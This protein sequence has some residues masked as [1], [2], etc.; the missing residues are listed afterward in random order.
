[1]KRNVRLFAT[2]SALLASLSF[3]SA[4]Q[5]Q[6][7]FNFQFTSVDNGASTGSGYLDLP[8]DPGNGTFYYGDLSPTY[9]FTFGGNS[10]NQSHYISNPYQTQ[11]VISDLGNGQRGLVFSD[12]GGPK[13]GGG[14]QYG[15]IDLDYADN[16]LTFSPANF[17]PG[18]L[19]ESGS[20][21][22]AFTA[23][24][25]GAPAATATPEPG[26]VA[27]FVGMGITGAALLRRRRRPLSSSR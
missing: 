14:Q 1:M 8:S 3:A 7:H 23:V 6:L 17:G 16:F 11:L 19:Y 2:W 13:N 27:M 25:S 21:S 22:G 12:N 24:A 20:G 10:Y 4:A 26:S 15:S 9:T 18:F 5:A